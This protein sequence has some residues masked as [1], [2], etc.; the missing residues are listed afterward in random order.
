M[1]YWVGKRGDV[2]AAGAGGGT[3][4]GGP[5]PYDPGDEKVLACA[6]GVCRYTDMGTP[7]NIAACKGK[8][9]G[10]P[11][12]PDEP[13]PRNKPPWYDCVQ[14]CNNRFP[15]GA[16][17]LEQCIKDCKDL[18]PDEPGDPGDP[19]DQ[20]EGCPEGNYFT[21]TTGCPEGYIYFPG[22]KR[23][24][25]SAWCLT[26]GYEAD[27]R[28]KKGG[29]APGGDMGEFQFPPEM[30]E[31]YKMMMARGKDLLGMPV[32]YT[33]DMIN[34]MYGKNFETLRGR[35]A[36][37][38]EGATRLLSRE[39]ALGTG[40][41]REVL[42]DVAWNTEDAIAN[43]L[44]DIFIESEK[45]KKTDILNYTQMANEL[46]TGGQ[47]YW[48]L[49]EAANAARRGDMFRSLELLL[50]YYGIGVSGYGG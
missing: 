41:G 24:E 22:K 31:Y 8:N 11:C 13:D 5:E 4:G 26:V 36:A 27:C 10:D 35:E 32:G 48:M 1:A 16:P 18:H 44:R 28:T 21:S 6:G 14:D 7:E 47:N 34:S 29:G 38:R 25:C 30:L 17:G 50:Q 19:G 33:K 45:Q 42:S 9:E 23:C 43:A 49:Q 39:G 37:Q 3:A 2:G 40:E 12:T 46:F 15:P 20:V